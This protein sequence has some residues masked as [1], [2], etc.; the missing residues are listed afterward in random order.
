MLRGGK[1]KEKNKEGGGQCKQNVQLKGVR[2]SLLPRESTVLLICLCVH[3]SN[4]ERGHM[5]A[6][7]CM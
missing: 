1:E 6:N 2:E 4:R 3:V 7:T 5:H